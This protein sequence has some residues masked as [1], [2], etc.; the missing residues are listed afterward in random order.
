[1]EYIESNR[2]E[3]LKTLIAGIT[4]GSGILSQQ[5]IGAEGLPKRPLGKT[6]EMIC[7]IGLGGA[8][9]GHIKDHDEAVSIMH[10]A[11]DEGLTFFD[12]CWEYHSGHSERIMGKALSSNG[13][14]D[15]VFLMTK[16]C[17]RDYQGAKQQLEDSLKR[18]QTD[19]ID[20]W[21]FHGIK[22]D[23]DAGLIFNPEKG[24]LKAAL[25]AR[26]AGKIR[27]IGFTG[28]K[29]P[30]YH[31][32]MLAQDFEW[33]SVL[34]PLNVLDFHYRSFQK[35]VMPILNYREIG[36]LGMKALASQNGRL[37]RETGIS[38]ELARRYVLSLPVTSLLCGIRS[39]DN[40]RQDIAIARNFKPLTEQEIKS[41]VET[42]KQFSLDGQIEKYKTGDYG[43]NWFRKSTDE[44]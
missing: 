41:L 16:V 15:K 36:I 43:C 42:S 3:F 6:G 39:R 34:I 32:S 22:W 26:K 37:V 10:E 25:E 2:R 20:L 7:I 28:H 33:D 18:L 1:M 30:R 40:L 19:R 31:L 11:I 35:E 14:R 24:A 8:D 27:Y 29:D 9:I 4:M 21:Q 13:R 38:A 17:A 44:L 12:N 5:V 23:D